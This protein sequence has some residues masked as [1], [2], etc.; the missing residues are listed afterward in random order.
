MSQVIANNEYTVVI[1]RLV[2]ARAR[3]VKTLFCELKICLM[4]G[5]TFGYPRKMDR[6]DLK[7]RRP[8]SLLSAK[9]SLLHSVKNLTLE[10]ATC[11]SSIIYKQ[12]KG[13]RLSKSIKWIQKAA[14]SITT[15]FAIYWLEESFWF[16]RHKSS[17]ETVEK[18]NE[19]D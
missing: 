6:L 16:S 2:Y 5:K 3:V 1:N 8:F 7:N 17:N 18:N 14:V 12:L 10:G 4:N 15:L 9:F 11:S 13:I 19:Q